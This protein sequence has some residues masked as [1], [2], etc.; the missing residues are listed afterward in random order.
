M[1]IPPT[2]TGG[3][4]GTE[5]ITTVWKITLAAITGL[6]G[7]DESVTRTTTG[8]KLWRAAMA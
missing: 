4:S 7:L 8:R 3:G 6:A 5:R 1:M 2:E